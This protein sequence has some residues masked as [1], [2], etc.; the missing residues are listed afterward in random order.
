MEL[1]ERAK[2]LLSSHDPF[3]FV[4]NAI[5]RKKGIELTVCSEMPGSYEFYKKLNK[6]IETCK[7]NFQGHG[8]E[9]THNALLCAPLLT[10]EQEQHL[11][12]QMNF[13]KFKSNKLRYRVRR[14]PTEEVLNTFENYVKEVK[15][16]RDVLIHCNIKLV[17]GV[18][19]KHLDLKINFNLDKYGNRLSDGYLSICLA[20]DRFD[21]SK[22]FR[23]ST[24]ATWAMY[25]NFS[26]SRKYENMK[27]A[28]LPPEDLPDIIRDNDDFEL[29]NKDN[30]KI[31]NRLMS[32]LDDRTADVVK[33]HVG[34]KQTLGQI[35][36]RLKLTRQ[37]TQRIK[38]GGM[39]RLKEVA[40]VLYPEFF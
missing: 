15:K 39:K 10:K 32:F 7:A 9:I 30:K 13:L 24:Y 12:R 33:C 5:F 20:V 4:D 36:E 1:K 6:N 17:S 23:F 19:K 2:S 11:F 27:E 16:I 22:N 21:Y 25:N 35:G 31:V 38:E 37:G 28:I 26:T 14:Y 34:E 40:G 8:R 3:H 18:L 29:R